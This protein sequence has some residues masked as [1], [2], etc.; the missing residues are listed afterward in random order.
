MPS[1]QVLDLS[2]DHVVR[3][4]GEDAEL[5]IDLDALRVSVC[6]SSFDLG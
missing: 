4:D 6:K 5:S 1:P 3:V 2:K